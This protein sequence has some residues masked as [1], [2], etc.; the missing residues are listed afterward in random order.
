M[1]PQESIELFE[2]FTQGLLSDKEVL[3]FEAKLSFD[4]EFKSHYD[5]YLALENDLKVHFQKNSLKNKLINTDAIIDHEISHSLLRKKRYITIAISIAAGVALFIGVYLGIYQG[6]SQ[7]NDKISELWP[8]EEGLPVQMGEMAL[9]QTATNAFK[10]GEWSKAI[11]L[12]E[13]IDSDT[14]C[15]FQ[16][17]SYYE[18]KEFKEASNLFLNVSN[19]SIY[20]EDAELRLAILYVLEGKSNFAKNILITISENKQHKHYELALRILKKL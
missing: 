4:S 15:Y 6:R 17:I 19:E 12:F 5:Q 9:Y 14:S 20:H 3:E 13:K 11:S 1:M 18:L 10:L 8:Y 2:R 16:A 7:S